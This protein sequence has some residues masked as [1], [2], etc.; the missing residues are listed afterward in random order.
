MYFWHVYCYQY[1]QLV[2]L[3]Q[4]EDLQAFLSDSRNLKAMADCYV[5][6]HPLCAKN[7]FL[8]YYWKPV[9]SLG[10]LAELSQIWFCVKNLAGSRPCAKYCPTSVSLP[11]VQP[12]QNTELCCPRDQQRKLSQSLMLDASKP[13]ARGKPER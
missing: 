7:D 8:K 9:L 2:G 6:L 10:L 11:Q 3:V 1:E 13:V 4:C 5:S 12:V